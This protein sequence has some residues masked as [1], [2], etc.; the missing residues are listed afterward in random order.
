MLLP[1]ERRSGE[2]FRP[3]VPTWRADELDR[4]AWLVAR[5]S[6][7][8]AGAARRNVPFAATRYGLGWGLCHPPMPAANCS[9]SAGPQ[10]PR[11]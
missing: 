6:G 9:V 11:S 4:Y 10:D 8:P 1:K 2:Q 5:I 7:S 3:P